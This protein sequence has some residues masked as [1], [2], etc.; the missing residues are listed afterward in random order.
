MLNLTSARLIAGRPDNPTTVKTSEIDQF[1]RG[2]LIGIPGAPE[3]MVQNTTGD[4]DWTV[5]D[6]LSGPAT[7]VTLIAAPLTDGGER[8]TALPGNEAILV[9]NET[10]P[11]AGTWLLWDGRR[12]AIDL[13]D[14]AVI[15]A[16]G[17]GVGGSRQPFHR[18]G[19]V[20]RDSRGP[21]AECAGPAGRR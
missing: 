19:S 16:L 5:C 18:A 2:N 12:S 10:G 9:A 1:A 14:R 4:A 3:R 11:N 8:A 6:G 15:G 21:G 20:Q 7:G 13:D 17:L